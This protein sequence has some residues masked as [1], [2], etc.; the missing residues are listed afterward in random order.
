VS[1]EPELTPELWFTYTQLRAAG[2]LGRAWPEP[3][4][5]KVAPLHALQWCDYASAEFMSCARFFQL[6][7]ELSG[8]LPLTRVGADYM[9]VAVPSAVRIQPQSTRVN[10]RES[11][12]SA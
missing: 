1:L 12:R 7:D 2:R 4:G 8:A 11:R 3:S 6:L 10:V 5:W 9:G